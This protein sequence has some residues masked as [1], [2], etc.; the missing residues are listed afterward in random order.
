MNYIYIHTHMFVYESQSNNPNLTNFGRG[1]ISAQISESII[2]IT[3]SRT[4]L[5]AFFM[6][7]IRELRMHE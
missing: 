4:M 5:Y 1:E 3:P 2:K 6:T 7:T